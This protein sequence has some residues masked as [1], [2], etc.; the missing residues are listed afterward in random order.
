MAAYLR[1]MRRLFPNRFKNLPKSRALCRKIHQFTTYN[2]NVNAKYSMPTV[3]RLQIIQSKS[4]CSQSP[5]VS[6]RT[7]LRFATIFLYF[8]LLAATAGAIIYHEKIL[9]VI[10][11]K[12][13]ERRE[14]FLIKCYPERIILIRHGQSE[15]NI[16][17]HVLGHTP[18]HAIKLTRT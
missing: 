17:Q 6:R 7:Q 9:S 2:R 14:S 13:F 10:T 3:R 4:F 12:I 15:A 18:D 1:L 5:K 16:D 11:M 8:P